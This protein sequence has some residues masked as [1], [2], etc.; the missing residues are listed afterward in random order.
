MIQTPRTIKRLRNDLFAIV[1]TILGAKEDERFGLSNPALAQQIAPASKKVE[2]TLHVKP[3]VMAKGLFL[4]SFWHNERYYADQKIPSLFVEE[5]LC[6]LD[7]CDTHAIAYSLEHLGFCEHFY[8]Q[9]ITHALC[10]KEFGSSDKALIFEPLPALIPSL[11]AYLK[12]THYD[13]TSDALLA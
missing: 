8:P 5:L 13:V 2:I 10:K 12:N 1:K 9:F 3:T 7:F 11:I 6:L 4:S